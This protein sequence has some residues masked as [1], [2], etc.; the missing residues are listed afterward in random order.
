MLYIVNSHTQVSEGIEHQCEYWVEI[1]ADSQFEGHGF[2][3]NIIVTT[4]CSSVVQHE[5]LQMCLNLR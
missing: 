1:T 2:K 5:S 4:W 3:Y